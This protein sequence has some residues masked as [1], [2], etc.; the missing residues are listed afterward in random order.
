MTRRT[1]VTVRTGWFSSISGPSNTAGIKL[2]EYLLAAA[3]ALASTLTV[4]GNL[5]AL[6]WFGMWAGLNSKSAN[7]ATL[8]TLA[9]VQIIP[10]FGIAIV[11]TM[12]FLPLM[13]WPALNGKFSGSGSMAYMLYPL[14][15]TGV[16]TV[17]ALTKDTIFILWAR[18][19]LRTHFR[20][21]VLP[22]VTS[23]HEKLP[24]PLPRVSPPPLI[25]A[26]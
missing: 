26:K 13:L 3:I 22:T 19:K 14:I 2:S 8:K 4:L 18:K 21:C 12:I 7:I 1:T 6:S 24:P 17:L 11:S 23:I 20:E 5:A 10:W 15:T 9:F 25:A 16:A